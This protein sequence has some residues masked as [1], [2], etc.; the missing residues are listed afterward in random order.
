MGEQDTPNLADIA[1]VLGFGE[2]IVPV[3]KPGEVCTDEGCAP[4][5]QGTAP[6]PAQAEDDAERADGE[7]ANTERA[8]AGGRQ[9]EE[10]R[11][12]LTVDEP[13]VARPMDEAQPQG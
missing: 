13:E 1:D 6:D 12:V 5:P 8:D 3:A 10:P 11:V 9:I 2:G 7:Q 4:V